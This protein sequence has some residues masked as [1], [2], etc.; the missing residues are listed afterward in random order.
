MKIIYTVVV[1]DYPDKLANKVQDLSEK[2]YKPL[3]GIC[4]TK[5]MG[6]RLHAGCYSPDV[7][8]ECYQAMIKRPWWAFWL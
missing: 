2:G 1:S 4:V 8:M 6:R 5:F 3:G 7:K